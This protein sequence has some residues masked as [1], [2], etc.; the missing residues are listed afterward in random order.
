MTTDSQNK[1]LIR[2]LLIIVF[3][4][5]VVFVPESV[6]LTPVELLPI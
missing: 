5:F 4:V 2:G 6:K 1:H 3:V